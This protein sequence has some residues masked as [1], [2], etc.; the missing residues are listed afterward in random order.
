M[1]KALLSIVVACLLGI[2]WLYFIIM[3]M[4]SS[5]GIMFPWKEKGET[6]KSN[7][8]VFAYSTVISILFYF[9]EVFIGN[10]IFH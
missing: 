4:Y 1:D 6:R 2:P 10:W 7:L 8:I 5:Y 9:F 3:A